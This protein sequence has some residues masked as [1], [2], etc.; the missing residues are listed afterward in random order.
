MTPAPMTEIADR[1]DPAETEARWYGWWE[2]RGSF[3]ADPS[4]P[5]TPYSIVIPPPNVTGSLHMGHALDNT[6]QDVLIRY[7][8]MDGYKA[9]W[10]P[11]TDHAGIATQYVMERQLAAEETGKEAIGREA[12]L[13]RMWRW[14]EESRGTI[15]A[16]LKR[17]GA[18][19]DWRRERFTMDEGLSRAVR[20]AFV[21]LHRKGL[22]YRGRYI[23]NWCPRCRT[24]LSDLEVSY[25]ETRGTLYYIKYPELS[26]RRSVTVATT[27][28]ETML[29]DT[30]VMVHPKDA[31][32]AG[33]VG[34]K[35][36]LPLADRE[37][38]IIADEA[39]DMA[40][41]SGAVKVTPA[42]DMNDFDVG[43]RHG[44]PALVVMD[45]SAKMNDKA[46]AFAG[47]DRFEAREKIV[48]RLEEIG[49]LFLELS[50]ELGIENASRMKNLMMAARP[51]A[52]SA[53]PR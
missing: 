15:I 13:A 53:L 34:K 21:R 19:C 6:L 7:K 28:P 3:R 49:L 25:E 48:G 33:L 23:I 35:A 4:K 37:I 47:L 41:G 16:Q 42:R 32:Y 29:G 2:E 5:G 24:A 52:T 43:K 20:E 50:H 10:V 1:Y 26:G 8:R 12:F 51:S 36:I 9:L 38:P 31:R 14:K 18:S 11:G 27:R 46:G 45:E 39:V 44:L 22:V 40:F 17:L 30:A